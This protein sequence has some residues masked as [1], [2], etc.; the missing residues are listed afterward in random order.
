MLERGC[1]EPSGRLWGMYVFDLRLRVALQ[2]CERSAHALPVR[3]SDVVVAAHKRGNG[4]FGR[5]VTMTSAVHE[6][7][8]ECLTAPCKC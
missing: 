4:Y 2:L 7:L 3:Q 5:E 8:V 1:N 6:L